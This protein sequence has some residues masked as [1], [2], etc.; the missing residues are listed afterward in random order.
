[1]A[2]GI[3]YRFPTN[4]SLD[5][6]TQEY[7][8]QRDQMIGDKIMPFREHL[9]QRVQWDELDSERGMTAPHN[10]KSD[11]RV[12]KRSGSRVREY[13]PIPFKE[14][15]PITEDELL[16]ARQAATLGG[17]IDLH[18]LVGRR[19]KAREDKTFIRAEWC[20]WQTLRGTLDINENG[21]RVHETFPV[22]QYDV[23]NDWDDR[24]AATPLRDFNAVKLLFR[25]TGASAKGAIAY[26]NQTTLNW[27]L[28]NA[29]DND[30]RG[31][32]GQNFL[33]LAF[34]L[35][36][37]NTIL[38]D[39]GLPTLELYDEGYIDEDGDWQNF[40]EDGEAI[41]IGKRPVGQVVGDFSMTPSLHRQKNGVPVGGFF[42]IIEVNGQSN[43][44]MTEVSLA[45]LGA[46]KNP[47]IEITG[48]VYGGTR[49]LYP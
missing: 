35:T 8:I 41:V 45:D 12:D 44:G 6:A 19:I 42:T 3:I 14:T 38:Q 9:T 31:F 25:G 49:L 13:T 2:A 10:M 43:R 21:V 5:E 26:V 47:N 17:V 39:R 48:G 24:E 33:S 15:E 34:S 23:I 20:R 18:D 16:Q 7:F 30:L 32:R 28:E 1:M 40:I 29:N 11:P 27:L 22:Q 4:V 46:G 37:L 36:Q